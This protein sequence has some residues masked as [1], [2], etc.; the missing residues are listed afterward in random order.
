MTSAAPAEVVAEGEGVTMPPPE[1]NCAMPPTRVKLNSLEEIAPEQ[2][3]RLWDQQNAYVDSLEARLKELEK[4][5][6]VKGTGKESSKREALLTCR[7]TVKEQ[8]LQ[9]MVSQIAE[10]KAA[11][12]PSTA[13]LR[14]TLIDPAVN[15]VIQ[16]LTKECDALKKQA[17]EARD[18]L[19]A[20]KF[21]PDSA[22]GKRLM[23]KC[24]Q[25]YQENEDLG[26]MIAS[27][28]LAKLEGELAL[29]KNLTEE[30]KKNQLEMDEFMAELDEDVE[31]MQST[32]Y[33]LQQQLR[34]AKETIA[35]LEAQ[36]GNVNGDE[37][38]EGE[39]SKAERDNDEVDDLMDGAGG[40][41]VGEESGE[42]TSSVNPQERTK[43][44]D[45]RV[46]QARTAGEW[47]GEG[48]EGVVDGGKSVGG[49]R[50]GR[51]SSPATSSPSRRTRT[52]SNSPAPSDPAQDI[53]SPTS[54][55]GKGRGRG[56]P[57]SRSGVKDGDQGVGGE[58]VASKE[59]EGDTV[60]TEEEQQGRKG[61]RKKLGS[62]S[63]NKRRKGGI[64]EEEEDG[65]EKEDHDLK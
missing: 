15:L 38:A 30:M 27:G 33:Y 11:Q 28:R 56:R 4:V 18:E 13:A 59:K 14:N 22:T 62:K 44:S 49:H 50:G 52:S 40:L 20:W 17:E 2:V 53:I 48:S 64:S 41:G 54:K 32:I 12:A 31:G 35:R 45:E 34:E 51:T 21:T 25:L 58:E 29:Q 26:K 24:R 37:L 47:D 19:A 7:L 39:V 43:D 36:N 63:A 16:K 60:V 10:L 55:R 23:A 3:A 42:Q 9:E 5:D 57:S 65:E 61:K 8:E 6:E 1:E 46:D